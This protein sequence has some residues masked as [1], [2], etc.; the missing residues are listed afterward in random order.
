[1]KKIL[2]LIIILVIPILISSCGTKDY[3][4]GQLVE[5]SGI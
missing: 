5:I 1:M 4:E 3:K 2:K